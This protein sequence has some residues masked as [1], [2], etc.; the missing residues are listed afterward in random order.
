MRIYHLNCISMCPL[1]GG[2]M[3]GHSQRAVRG[4]LSCH[5]L[6]IETDRALVL[7]DTGFGLL[8]VLAPSERLSRF[9]MAALK[10]AFHQEATAWGQIKALGFSPSDVRHIVLTHLDFDHAGG[11]DDFPQARVHLLAK[12]RTAASARRTLLDRGRYRPQQWATMPHWRTYEA[13]EGEAWYGF[14][15]VHDLEGLPP[16][17]LL[18]PLIGHTLGHA[19][20]AVQGPNGWLLHAGDAYFYHAEMAAHPYCTPGLQAYQRMMEKNRP[21]RLWNQ[22]RLRR[23]AQE[24]RDDVTVFCSHDLQEFN[25]LAHHNPRPGV[26]GEHHAPTTPRPAWPQHV[27]HAIV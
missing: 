2:L 27:H 7:V 8:D 25:A 10:P 18:V 23:L 9:F 5:C 24:H 26:A 15:S 22:E 13:G 14:D 6:L 16:E 4:E 11:L 17:I 12:E 3:D 21:A 1:G 20:V 19:G